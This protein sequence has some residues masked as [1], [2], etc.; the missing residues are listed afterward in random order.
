[1]VDVVLVGLNDA[2]GEESIL[3]TVN[4]FDVCDELPWTVSVPVLVLV[5]LIVLVLVIVMVL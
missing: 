5:L 1:M 3:G 2:V 4:E